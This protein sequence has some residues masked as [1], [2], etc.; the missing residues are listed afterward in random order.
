M[1]FLYLAIALVVGYLIG[2]ISFARIFTWWIARKDIT[3]EGSKNPGTMNILRTRG[4]GEAILTLVFDAL[5]V[6]GPALAAYFLFNHFFPDYGDVAYFVTAFAGIFGHCFPIY[7]KFKGGKGVASTFGMFLFNPHL[8]W[9]SIIMFVLCFILF[10]FL[11]YGFII[12]LLFIFVMTVYGAC[13]YG[14]N[15]ILW[16]LIIITILILNLI[17]VLLKH[18][19]NFKRFF[20]GTENK[21]DFKERVF[22]KLKKNKSS[23]FESNSQEK[24]S[25]EDEKSVDEEKENNDD[26]KEEVKESSEINKTDENSQN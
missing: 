6:G 16:Y 8:W 1:V 5:K 26:K 2:S 22:G 15:K 12:S 7:Y 3:T 11:E 23:N 14:I 9:L 19:G 20:A 13:F 4:F 17:L 21:V 25:N 24:S 18:R 10:F